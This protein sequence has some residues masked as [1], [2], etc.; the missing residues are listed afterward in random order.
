MNQNEISYD[1]RIIKDDVCFA[2]S[3]IAKLKI[4]FKA[5]KM[6]MCKKE[7]TKLFMHYGY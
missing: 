3:V 4:G 5:S 1:N 2:L 6:P 7:N